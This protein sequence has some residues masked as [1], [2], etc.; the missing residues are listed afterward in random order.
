M[1]E[2]ELLSK[3]GFFNKYQN[4]KQAACS[5]FIAMYC[6]GPKMD[7]CKRKAYRTE[8]GTAPPDDMMPTGSMIID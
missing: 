3:C 8:H 4:S 1:A 5:G 6:K 2:C 7:V